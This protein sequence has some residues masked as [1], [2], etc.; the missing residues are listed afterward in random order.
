[1]RHHEVT[2][3]VL[4]SLLA[5]MAVIITVTACGT[6]QMG[7]TSGVAPAASDA[8]LSNS[9]RMVEEGRRT[10]RFDTFG[11]E[12]FWGDAIKLIRRSL[13]T[14]TPASAV[15]SARRPRSPSA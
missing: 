13:A 10:F 1:M 14:S 12:A 7:P 4:V 11:S 5:F 2:G 15:A 6:T 8:A 3:P 9:H